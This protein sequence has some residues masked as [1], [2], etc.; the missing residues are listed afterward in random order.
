MRSQ[1]AVIATFAMF[2]LV[3]SGRAETLETAATHPWTALL[4]K[5]GTSGT[6]S[7]PNEP[8]P[9]TFGL[10]AIVGSE[11]SYH[12]S[13]YVNLW[14][15]LDNAGKLHPSEIG[16]VSENWRAFKPEDGSDESSRKNCV[17]STKCI[18]VDQWIYSLNPD[19]SLRRFE[20]FD[21]V[22]DITD[23][24]VVFHVEDLETSQAQGKAKLDALLSFWYQFEPS[25]P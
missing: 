4:H 9:A 18:Y 1:T 20:H 19:G 21:T 8:L 24:G 2:A 3:S 12:T 14:G 25:K 6:Y 11:T 17:P 22:R 7:P 10:Q 15:A 5:I 13:D 23:S 16:I